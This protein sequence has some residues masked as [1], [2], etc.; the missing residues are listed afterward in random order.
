MR[1]SD[2]SRRVTRPVPIVQAT[3]ETSS[4]TAA[5][6]TDQP[7]PACSTSVITLVPPVKAMPAVSASRQVA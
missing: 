5:Q 2:Q 7:E 3:L 6:K 1:R 4:G